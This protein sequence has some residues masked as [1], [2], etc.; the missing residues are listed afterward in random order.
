MRKSKMK[1]R[2]EEGECLMIVM[3]YQKLVVLSS[4]ITCLFYLST[5]FRLHFFLGFA[6]RVCKTKCVS[7]YEFT[8]LCMAK[9]LSVSI[10][11]L[12]GRRLLISFRGFSWRFV[13]AFLGRGL[14]S[15][16]GLLG[17]GLGSCFGLLGRGL[18]S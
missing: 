2:N 15:C 5:L 12:I 17:R 8:Y 16:F 4:F 1:L 11:I 13:F 10:H 6:R 9:L 14:G 3:V 18:G 7:Y